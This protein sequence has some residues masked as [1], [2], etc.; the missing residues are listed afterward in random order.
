[1]NVDLEWDWI[2]F[3]PL[4]FYRMDRNVQKLFVRDIILQQIGESRPEIVFFERQ[5]R[6]REERKISYTRRKKVIQDFRRW[7]LAIEDF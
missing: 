5:I 7:H 6:R 3:V 1:V 4:D 2:D